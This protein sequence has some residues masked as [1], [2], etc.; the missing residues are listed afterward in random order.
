MDAL[1]QCFARLKVK[2]LK[3][4]RDNHTVSVILRI[5]DRENKLI[6][7]APALSLLKDADWKTLMQTF[8]L[9]S[10]ADHILIEVSNI[11]LGGDF[12]ADDLVFVSEP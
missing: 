9:P 10:N 3:V 7:Y 5:R 8:D 4:G 11:G 12:W 6:A 1:R 2:G